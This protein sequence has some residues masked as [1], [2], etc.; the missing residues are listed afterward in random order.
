M[1]SV[2]HSHNVSVFDRACGERCCICLITFLFLT[3]LVERG[4]AY[5]LSQ[6]NVNAAGVAFFVCKAQKTL[7][8][9]LEDFDNSKT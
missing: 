1:L 6:R 3:G 4:V 2:R 9:V 7:I 8:A 5:D